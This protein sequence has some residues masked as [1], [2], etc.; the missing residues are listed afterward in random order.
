MEAEYNFNKKTIIQVVTGVS[1]MDWAE[2]KCVEQDRAP[3]SFKTA[4]WELS[5]PSCFNNDI[6]IFE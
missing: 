6:I 1:V 3:L 4:S 5:A 2:G